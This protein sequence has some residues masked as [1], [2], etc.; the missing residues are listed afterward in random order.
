MY[1]KTS[2]LRAYQIIQ[3][4][5][6]KYGSMLLHNFNNPRASP[7]HMCFGQN[8]DEDHSLLLLWLLLT[9]IIMTERLTAY[10]CVQHYTR[11]E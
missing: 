4:T 11:K 10:A 7:Y 5:L 9:T 8:A 2:A 1:K 6:E 3:C